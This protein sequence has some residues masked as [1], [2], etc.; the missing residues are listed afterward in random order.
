[1]KSLFLVI[2]A[3]PLLAGS[4]KAQI[5]PYESVTV[6]AE[7]A[8]RIVDLNQSDELKK[9]D[10]TVLVIDHA[11]ESAELA[12]DR[13]KLQ[14]IDRQIVIKQRQYRRIKDLK[15][16]SLFTK[17]R[18]LNELLSLRLQREDL[19]NR[20]ATLEDTIAKKEIAVHDRYLKKLYVRKGTYVAP[21]MKLMD[22]EDLEGSRIVLYLDAADRDRLSEKEIL[23]DGKR[24]H[25]YTIDK[26]AATTDAN[27]ISS[28]RVELVRKGPADFGRV[29]TVE[30]GE[31]R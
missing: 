15:G 30:I 10:K 23:I 26:A 6:S 17:E 12:N 19:K 7:K 2:C 18:Y 16:Q 1:M 8:G 22:L 11:L 31:K 25:G 13:E 28:Y 21:G 9:V 27:Y 14:L 24:A 3:L 5:E 20:I 29:V 4:Y